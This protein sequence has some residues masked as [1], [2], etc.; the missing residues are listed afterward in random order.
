MTVR[1]GGAALCALVVVT[2]GSCVP[3]PV[4][5][6]LPP[7]G[8]TINLRF[9]QS[10]GLNL[11]DYDT[12]CLGAVRVVM[13]GERGDQSDCADLE[14]RPANLEDFVFAEDAEVSFGTLADRGEVIFRVFGLHDVGA[15][16]DQEPCA[17]AE[18]PGTW[19]F[20]G[21]SAPFDLGT[22][23]GADAGS[24]QIVVPVDCRDCAGGCSQ[25]GTALCPTN[26]PSY[27]IPGTA[28]L[29]CAI[30][31]DDDE[32]CFEGAIGCDKDIGRCDATDGP[33]GGLCA[34]CASDAECDIAQGFSCVGRP[35]AA[36]G[37]CALR[38]PVNR[39]VQG[40]KCNRLGNDL[41]LIGVLPPDAGT[42][43]DGG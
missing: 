26:P 19:L 10:C 8:L 5:E 12:S 42:L 9:R 37:L 3:P 22:L 28:N 21:E 7:V 11:A 36:T 17:A 27:C 34:S 2:A 40:T 35:G 14:P 43:S 32:R 18:S 33:A 13:E 6:P 39:C 29:T 38:C 15:P 16:E 24:V 41:Q 25:L 1:W 23:R 30:P 31:C 4:L 20:F